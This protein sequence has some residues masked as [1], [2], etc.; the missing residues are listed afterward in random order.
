MARALVF[1]MCTLPWSAL[2]AEGGEGVL[3]WSSLTDVALRVFARGPGAS[4]ERRQQ[5][6]T[7]AS[8]VVP[9][10]F[11]LLS[12]GAGSDV[13]LGDAERYPAE[14]GLDATLL[15]ELGARARTERE[16]LHA[17][18]EVLEAEREAAG[19]S[20][21]AEVQAA[22]LRW[23]AAERLTLHLSEDLASIRAQMK[24]LALAA[25][26][27][28]ISRLRFSD[29]EVEL[30]RLEAE[31]ARMHRRGLDRGFVLR[32]MLLFEV[33]LDPEGGP[34]SDGA[35][36]PAFASCDCENPWALLLDRV[37]EFPELR[38]LEAR[39][40]AA[41]ARARAADEASPFVLGLG[42]SGRHERPEGN[43]VGAAIS[44]EVP[45]A[46]DGAAD[47]ARARAEAEALRIDRAWRVERLRA[48][49]RAEAERFDATLALAQR[50]KDD[51]LGRLVERQHRQEDAIAKGHLELEALIRAW[52]DVH[53]AHHAV[54]ETITDL[55]AHRGRAGLITQFLDRLT[56]EQRREGETR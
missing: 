23:W 36:E 12:F 15:I 16:A 9:G 35:D 50:L 43:W 47:H 40:K 3:R 24:P 26:Q 44:L 1:A 25:E 52:R 41:E 18:R 4:N 51:Y 17:E 48:M 11:R 53:E 7:A 33:R 20:F 34:R 2:A 6:L 55:A 45:L 10:R 8:D 22:Y 13:P 19:W 5:G 32:A 39:V 42:G 31:I 21:V 49:L 27:G 56:H 38:V 29:L 46:N 14:I 30:Y 37:E 54:V 28:A